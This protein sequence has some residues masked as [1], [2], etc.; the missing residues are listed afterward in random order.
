MRYGATLEEW[1]RWTTYRADLLPVVCRPDQDLHTTSKLEAYGKVPSRYTIQ[2]T[3]VGF[4]KWTTYSATD[5]DIQKWSAEMDYGICLQTRQLRAL[6]FDITDAAYADYLKDSLA[7]LGYQFPWRTRSNS[8][9]FLTLIDV[10]GTYGKRILGTAHGCIEFLAN[11]QQCLVAGTHSSGVRY[12]WDWSAPIP[13][14]DADGLTQLLNDLEHLVSAGQPSQH[15]W[16]DA[17]ST[18]VVDRSSL[19]STV[20]DPILHYLELHGLVVRTAADGRAFLRCPWSDSHSTQSD[21]TATCWFPAGTAGFEQGHFKCLHAHCAGRTDDDF[22]RAIG[23]DHDGFEVIGTPVGLGQ[24]RRVRLLPGARGSDWDDSGVVRESTQPTDRTPSQDVEAGSE[25]IVRALTGATSIPVQDGPHPLDLPAF[26]R[27]AK[28]KIKPNAENLFLILTR[29]D[30]TGMA[31]AN[32]AFMNRLMVRHWKKGTPFHN[33]PELWT[34]EQAHVLAD[35]DAYQLRRLLCQFDLAGS[36]EFNPQLLR[37]GL[38]AAGEYFGFDSAINWTHTLP[39]WDGV[40]RIERF[41][42]V[43]LGAQDTPYTRAVS[44][45]WWTAHAGR[46]FAPGCQ[47]DMAVV[48]ISSQGTGKTSSLRA[49]PPHIDQYAELSL[50]DLGNDISRRIGGRMIGELA[51]LSGLHGHEVERVKAWVSCRED[52]WIKKYEERPFKYARRLVLVG[53]T[54]QEEFLADETG[55]RRWLPLKLS[56]Q[57]PDWIARDRDQLWVEA[58]N[59]YLMSGVM[60]MEAEALAKPT[61]AE[62]LIS[63]SWEGSVRHWLSTDDGFGGGTPESRGTLGMGEIFQG[64]LGMPPHQQSVAAQHRLGKILRKMGFERLRILTGGQRERLW[65]TPEWKKLHGHTA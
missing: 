51:E 30:L 36:A 61:H 26:L 2:R 28:G 37:E 22:K 62:H 60:W 12:E 4:T 18:R 15:T 32:D 25:T 19:S 14:L 16:S 54:N 40:P 27:N 33:R 64:A 17:A 57:H 63:D 7:F 21:L 65:V 31:I 3:V 41:A 55:N 42:S 9:K 29:P 10:E 45:Y 11:G 8:S 50:H 24:D 49:I 34:N 48:L 46:I 47:A 56:K 58:L 5:S 44:L 20:D 43:Y 52:E 38:K 13:S 1:A 39:E 35:A 23:Y 59:L 6:D 53:T